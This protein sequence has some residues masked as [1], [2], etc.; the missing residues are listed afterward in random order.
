MYN[1]LSVSK[2][3]FKSYFTNCQK[4]AWFFSNKENFFEGVRLKREKIYDFDAS[5]STEE[6]DFNS[7][8]SFDILTEFEFLFEEGVV[9]DPKQQEKKDA[10]MEQFSSDNGFSIEAFKGKQI[11]DGLLAGLL[12]QE[13]FELRLYRENKVFKESKVSLNF[14]SKK[15]STVLT[16]EVEEALKDN[17]IKY[18]YEPAFYALNG[19][20][21]TRCDILINKGNKHVEIVEVKAVS[22]TKTEHIF[23]VYYQKKVL[24]LCGYIVDKVYLLRLNKEYIANRNAGYSDYDPK[25]MPEIVFDDFKD[26]IEEMKL[27]KDIPEAENVDVEIEELFVLDD[28]GVNKSKG[29]LVTLEFSID[30]LEK[31]MNFEESINAISEYLQKPNLES[32]Y[33]S[34]LS[35]KVKSELWMP[36]LRACS[37][38]FKHMDS[39]H[40]ILTLKGSRKSVNME[41]VIETGITDLKEIDNEIIYKDGHKLFDSSKPKEQMRVLMPYLNGKKYKVINPDG[42]EL[43]K[44]ELLNYKKYPVYMYDF[45]TS[46]WAIPKFSGTNSY[47]QVPFQYSI[48]VLVD[49]NFDVKNKKSYKH[50][51]FLS[52][53][54]TDP[55]RSFV[56]NFII[57]SFSQGPGIYV[58]YNMSFEKTV[59]SKLM[60]EFPEYIKPLQYIYNNTID[61]MY[62][63]NKSAPKTDANP[64]ACLMYHP[65]F[66]GSYSIKYTQP[67]LYPDL[68]YNDLKVNK[69]DKAS[70]LFRQFIDGKISENTY[71]TVLY[72]DMLIYCNRDTAAMVALLQSIIKLVEEESK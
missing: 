12:A 45:E 70:E 28:R 35:L 63:F 30:C 20:V 52:K 50:Y 9:L 46:T 23:D 15:M 32:Q 66:K 58:A 25:L 42:L 72:N 41:F 37:H 1:K 3:D 44:E 59:L 17:N 33:C 65:D 71:A 53:L 62:F 43:V 27:I 26:L 60:H 7:S 57:D 49:D 55:R 13:Y 39:K 38:V 10:L 68:N 31:T 54:K 6:K 16:D 14:E 11:E 8:V 64:M 19:M 24:E 56:I 2:E 69:G 61:L 18:L 34:K 21:K 67:A 51:E 36:E 4:L 47:Q 29:E 48:D 40:N 5:I 22:K